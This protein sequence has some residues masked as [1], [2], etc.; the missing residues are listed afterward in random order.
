MIS[1]KQFQKALWEGTLK[2]SGSLTSIVIVLIIIFLFSEGLGLFKKN[3]MED[4]YT[5]LVSNNNP[6]KEISPSELKNV[7]DLKLISWKDLGWKDEQI[8]VMHS[9]DELME[10]EG[11]DNTYFIA[12]VEK[13]F[14]GD[15]KGMR[16]IKVKNI[17]LKSFFLGKEWM[18][19]ATPAAQLG[20]FPLILGTLWVSLIAILISLPL[21][22][23]VAAY[24]SFLANGKMRAFLKPTI[25]LLAA[26]P[27]VVYGFFGLVV[28]V[29]LVQRIFSLDVGE[30]AFAGGIVLAIM[31]L[32]T[33]ITIAEDAMRST[34]RSMVE[35]SLALGATRWQTIRKIIIPYSISGITAAGVLGMGR[36]IGETMAALMVTGNAAD[37]PTG[38]FDSVRTIPATIAA[39]LGE[40]TAGG[41]HYQALFILGCVLFV[42]T[43]MINLIVDL[44]KAKTKR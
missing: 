38:I 22:L 41:A 33:I 12:Q 9:I 29:P 30:S 39:E 35:C 1:K 13:D 4:G 26:I 20:I 15:C 36:A 44:V 2:F 40:T 24:L 32:P 7:F 10:H 27:S 3:G 16:E 28:I 25:E 23:A 19:T 18:P 17:T 43:L 31:T 11:E 14:I 8:Q 6:I 37:I 42:I 34:P 21:G 5:I